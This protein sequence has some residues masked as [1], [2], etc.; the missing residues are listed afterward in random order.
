MPKVREK[1]MTLVPTEIYF[2]GHLVKVEMALVKGKQLHDKRQ[3]QKDRSAQRPRAPIRPRAGRA[4]L[5]SA[6]RADREPFG[7][8]PLRRSSDGG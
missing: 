2:Q 6:D 4:A 1:G 5:T 8:P 7:V 3:V